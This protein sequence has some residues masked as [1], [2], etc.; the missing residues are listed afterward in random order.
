MK[1]LIGLLVSSWALVFLSACNQNEPIVFESVT[2]PGFEIEVETLLELQS[3]AF[4]LQGNLVEDEYLTGDDLNEL[5]EQLELEI[6]DV[7]AFEFE[8]TIELISYEFEHEVDDET[9]MALPSLS[10]DVIT[11][12][13]NEI[14]SFPYIIFENAGVF[15]Y[16]INQHTASDNDDDKLDNWLLTDA[17]V[18]IVVTVSEDVET[19]SLV[20]GVEQEIDI[21]FVNIFEYDISEEVRLVVEKRWEV[22]V[23]EAYEAGYEYVLND[24]GEYE[25]VAI[26]VPEPE[27]ELDVEQPLDT[28]GVQTSPPSDNNVAQT[29][30]SNNGGN[31]VNTGGGNTNAPPLPAPPPPPPVVEYA[32]R[33]NI[34]QYI[35]DPDGREG[36]I[37]WSLEPDEWV[38]LR[39]YLCESEGRRCTLNHCLEIVC[40]GGSC[41]QTQV[42]CGPEWNW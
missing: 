4:T 14:A 26:Y 37:I 11:V 15:T 2:V 24:D 7:P 40:Q 42:A 17:S 28:D 16:R 22:H 38:N 13:D 8:F 10:M 27:S 34:T 35:M 9:E 36:M 18:Y 5:L 3:A 20:A 19:E 39:S 23:A 1:K 41:T 29:P 30:P 32:F 12:A 33:I 31:E 6:P 21:I 25:R